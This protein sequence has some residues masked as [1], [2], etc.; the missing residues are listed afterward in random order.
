LAAFFFFTINGD[1][2]GP[3][4]EDVPEQ[5]ALCKIFAKPSEYAVRS[6]AVTALIEATKEGAFVW[7]PSCRGRGLS[8]IFSASGNGVAELRRAL[9]QHGLG[10]HPVVGTLTGSVD[11]NYYD[12]IRNVH[13]TVFRIITARDIHRSE[14]IERP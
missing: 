14:T 3:T 9:S 11:L 6:L 13:R 4:N 5:T 2:L 10:D 7:T 1:G 8:L 12:E